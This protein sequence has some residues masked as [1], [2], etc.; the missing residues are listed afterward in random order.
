[1]QDRKSKSPSRK[2]V[3]GSSESPGKYFNAV[4]KWVENVDKLD[5][6]LEDIP[7]FGHLPPNK[8]GNT[9]TQRVLPESPQ[10]QPKDKGAEEIDNNIDVNK[11]LV[12]IMEALKEDDNGKK[13][14]YKKKE[15]APLER[16]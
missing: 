16:V 7:L 9:T 8:D 12:N 5:D 14:Q 11:M 3:L 10:N 2:P 1:M 15:Y 4:A 6:E 13:Q